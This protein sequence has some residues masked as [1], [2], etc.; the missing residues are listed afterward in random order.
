MIIH[1]YHTHPHTL[2]TFP[3]TDRGREGEKERKKEGE[4]VRVGAEIKRN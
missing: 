4:S 2:L 3:K 1:V